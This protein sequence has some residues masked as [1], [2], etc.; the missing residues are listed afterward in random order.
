MEETYQTAASETPQAVPMAEPPVET[1]A[2]TQP[3]L[4]TAPVATE[5]P[6]IAQVGVYLSAGGG[7]GPAAPPITHISGFGGDRSDFLNVATPPPGFVRGP[8]YRTKRG[9]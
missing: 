2:E 3:E 5:E 4:E 6:E 9:K 8:S 1:P 7:Q